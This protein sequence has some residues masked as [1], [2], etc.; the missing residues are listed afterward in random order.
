[1][2]FDYITVMVQSEV[3]DRL[4]AKAG[5]SDYGAITAVIAYYGQAEV[6]FN[7]DADNFVPPPKVTSSV[8]RIRL[9]KE[10]PYHPQSEKLLMRTV[11][12]AFEQRRKTLPNA[13]SAAFSE[14]DKA[15]LTAC[16]EECGFPTTIRGEK[17]D[18]AD[19]VRLSDAIAA[20]L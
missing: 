1:M 9:H 18:I 16:V 13:L 12:A 11:K 15:T 2:P 6:L 5:T 19:F 8:V 7:V 10:K 14:L 3:A 20:K 17:L 4:C